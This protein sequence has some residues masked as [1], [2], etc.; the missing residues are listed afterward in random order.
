MSPRAQ[1]VILFGMM[2]M[3]GRRFNNEGLLIKLMPNS[4]VQLKQ[5]EEKGANRHLN[6]DV[7]V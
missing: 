2:E 5:E 6:L 7:A 3:I 4:K 1:L